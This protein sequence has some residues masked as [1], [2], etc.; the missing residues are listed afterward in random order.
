LQAEPAHETAAGTALAADILVVDDNPANLTAIE[1][2]LGDLGSKLV[3]AHSG[4]E[5]LRYLL[6][7]DVCLILLDVQMPDM[8]GFETARIIRSRA[9]TRHTP[10]IFVTAYSHQDHEVLAGY[11]LGAVDFLFKPIVGEVLRAKAQVFVEL[12]RQGAQLREHERRAHER[13]L[14]EEK[15]RWEAEALRREM[16]DKTRAAEA[17]R[18]KADE[19]ARTVTE[20]ERAE[21]DLQRINDELEAADRRKDEFLAML[22]HELRNPL[23]AIVTGLDL[24]AAAELEQ[25]PL[26][27]ARSAM[28]RQVRHLTRLVDDLL[29]VSRITSGKITLR[30]ERLDLNQAVQQALAMTRSLIDERGHQVAVELADPLPIEGDPVRLIQVASNLLQNAARYTEPGGTIQLATGRDGDHAVLRVADSGSGIDADQLERVFDL[31][32]QKDSN[33]TGLGLGLALVKRLV[34]LHHGTVR[35][36]SDGAGAGSTFTVRLPLAGG[37]ERST[38]AAAELAEPVASEP[39][40]I[41]VVE[42]IDDLRETLCALIDALGH[43]VRSA[44]NGRAGLDLILEARPDI[45]LIDI[46]MPEMD[47]HEVARRARSQLNGRTRLIAMTGFG[48][49]RDRERALEAGF[50]T[51]L[52]KPVSAETLIRIMARK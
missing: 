48:Q 26:R 29:D 25:P 18:R 27:M 9:R 51:H 21:K 43:R 11:S 38:C 52:T 40:D 7:H 32:V 37:A 20:K 17:L 49:D 14:A 1:A 15:Q 50:D 3:K 39:L 5:A 22:G 31:F 44:P 24:L 13:R 47:G 42:D 4:S 8:D 35:A 28:Q 2:A 46:S 12:H 23:G 34:Q 41:V 19:L 16:E 6:E 45:A 30:R 33:G 36:T 10:I